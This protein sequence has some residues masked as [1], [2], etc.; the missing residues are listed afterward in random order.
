MFIGSLLPKYRGA[1]PIQWAIINGDKKTGITTMYMNERMDEGDILLQKQIDIEDD[2][3]SGTLFE[4][5]GNLGADLLIETLIKINDGTIKGI[6][7]EGVASYAP[8]IKKE[9]AKLDFNKNA[10]DIVNLTR[11][12]NPFLCCYTIIKNKRYKIWKCKEITE[13]E[14]KELE[15]SNKEEKLERKYINNEIF[16]FKNRIFAKTFTNFIEIL[17]IQEEGKKRLLTQDFLRGKE[18]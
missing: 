8:M 11:G 15:K 7:Q 16:I 2:D 13:K 4:K 5:L 12:L 10:C 6:P 9:L 1:A 3:T 17:E 14:I 18:F